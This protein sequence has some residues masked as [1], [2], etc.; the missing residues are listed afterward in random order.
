MSRNLI[1][2]D[3]SLNNAEHEL[4]VLQSRLSQLLELKHGQEVIL[5]NRKEQAVRLRM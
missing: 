1:E 4:N 5:E 2:Q 3:M